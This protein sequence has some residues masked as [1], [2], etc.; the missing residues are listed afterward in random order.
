MQARF[1]PHLPERAEA[2]VIPCLNVLIL[3]EDFGTGLRAKHSL[4]ML[5]K[6]LFAPAPWSTK[7]WRIDLLSDP[8]LSEQAALE[9]A[10]AEVIILSVHGCGELSATVRE[11]LNT[12][13][14]RKQN[15]PCVLGVLLD[16]EEASQGSNN[17]VLT[18]AQQ[19]A[20]AAGANLIYGF[21]EAP[22]SELDSV[23]AE[24][25]ERAYQSSSV[26]EGM[27]KLSGSYRGWGIN[28]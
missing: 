18:H 26:L 16:S 8:L 21:S 17:P 15:R 12:W 10:A 25:N 6:Q 1:Q 7:L 27:L 2:A 20:T 3:Y 13:L 28:E 23:M 9:A 5:P 24:I 14:S 19:V 22:L 11:W 4:D